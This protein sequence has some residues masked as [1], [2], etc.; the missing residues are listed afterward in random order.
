MNRIKQSLNGINCVL[1]NWVYLMIF[2][3]FT[4]V[5]L[6][7]YI[8]AWNFILLSNFY[9]RI[10]LWTP[11]NLLFLITISILSGMILAL[12]IYVLKSNWSL[13]KKAHGYFALIPALFT[14]VCPTC[15]PLLLSFSS[16]TIGIGMLISG[17]N[18]FVN[19]FIVLLLGL[20]LINISSN[21]NSC[22]IK[23]KK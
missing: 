11:L 12:N 17:F 7:I 21:L 14:S 9:V 13:H 1:G 3:V 20:I 18:I 6:S 19:A 5:F 15:A 22:K 2:I 23:A 8:F 16:T 10:D 4:M